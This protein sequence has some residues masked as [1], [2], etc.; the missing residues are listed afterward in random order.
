MSRVQ[1]PVPTNLTGVFFVVF[2][3]HQGKCW[4]EFSLPRS[5]WPLFIYH[6]IK[7]VKLTNETLTTHNNRNT[8]PC[9]THPARWLR[10]NTR[11]SHSGGPGFKSRCRPAWL[12]FFPWFS[13]TIKANAGLDFHY[14]DPFDHYS[15][16][17]KLKISELYK[18][19][20]DN[21]TIEIQSFL[22]HTQRPYTRCDHRCWSVSK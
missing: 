16:I 9:S 13:W 12:W 4:V 22:I 15:Y 20:F 11:D 8:Q 2:L 3:N 7:S 1:I 21:T 10:G 5:I 6:K 14:H 19:N 17:I 18:W